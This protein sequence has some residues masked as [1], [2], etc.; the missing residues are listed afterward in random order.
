MQAFNLWTALHLEGLGCNLQ[1]V[2]PLVD[3]RIVSEW[4]VPVGW[5][6][7]AQLVFGAPTGEPGH[8]KTFTPTESR[9]FVHGMDSGK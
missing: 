8:E 1:H 2:N 9:V 4:N 6:L 3:Q 5:S 7:K